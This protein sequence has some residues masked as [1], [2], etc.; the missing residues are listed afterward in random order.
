MQVNAQE[1]HGYSASQFKPFGW[2]RSYGKSNLS[3]SL[4]CSKKSRAAW[5][6]RTQRFPPPCWL[7]LPEFGV[8]YDA[9]WVTKSD[10]P[11]G[12]WF[13][14]ATCVRIWCPYIRRGCID[15]KYCILILNMNGISSPRK[16]LEIYFLRGAAVLNA[17]ILYIDGLCLCICI[18]SSQT[19]SR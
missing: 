8:K 12:N 11:A 19:S 3:E 16:S 9:F 5:R 7:A 18:G 6:F 10:R 4:Q 14:F 13:R 15:C 17:K 1:L 2:T